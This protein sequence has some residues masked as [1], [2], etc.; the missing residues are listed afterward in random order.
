MRREVPTEFPDEGA[1][2]NRGPDSALESREALV[3]LDRA[4]DSLNEENREVFVLY[5]VEQ[6]PMSEVAKILDCPLQTAY[7]RH[8]AARAHVVAFFNRLALSKGGGE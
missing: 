5:E 2:T 6:L 8:A 7:S 4:L 3:M 1:T